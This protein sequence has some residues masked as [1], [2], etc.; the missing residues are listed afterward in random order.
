IEHHNDGGDANYTCSREDV[1]I[2]WRVTTDFPVVTNQVGVNPHLKMRVM[3][4]PTCSPQTTWYDFG[5]LQLNHWYDILYQVVWTPDSS[6]GQVNAWV[7]GAQVA[8]YR[9]P[10]LY[11]RPN[12][13]VSHTNF[14][15]V[16]YRLAANWNSTI[17]FGRELAGPT[18]ASVG[19]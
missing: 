12:G 2:D 11:L 3:G 17:Y 6:A 10:T 1:N 8:A 18:R 14:E 9:G 15:I 7:D 4:G 13:T 19:G 5:P 16:N